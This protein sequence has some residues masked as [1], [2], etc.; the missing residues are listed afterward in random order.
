MEFRA[1]DLVRSM[2]ERLGG[3]MTYERK[4]YVHGAWVIKIGQNDL[5]I[6][7]SGNRSFPDWISYILHG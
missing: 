1:Y 4:G 6:K 7:A 5:V 2:V 3:T